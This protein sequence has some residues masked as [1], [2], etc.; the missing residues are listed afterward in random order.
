MDGDRGGEETDTR[1]EETGDD[2]YG[3]GEPAQGK[4]ETTPDEVIRRVKIPPVVGGNEQHADDQ[5]PGEVTEDKLKEM[6]VRG[7]GKPRDAYE[8]QRARLACNDRK[9]HGPPGHPL[10]GEKIIARILL[11]PRDHHPRDGD[12]GEV[13]ND[14]GEIER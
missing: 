13:H 12:A 10:A 2:E 11:P 14:D 6:H 9:A 3:R 4:P 8:R 5:P 1:G 7:E